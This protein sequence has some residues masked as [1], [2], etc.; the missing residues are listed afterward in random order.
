MR[1]IVRIQGEVQTPRTDM[2]LIGLL[3]KAHNWFA[4]LTSGR[5]NSVCAIAKE[6]GLTRAYVNKVIHLAFLAPGIVA[7]CMRGD[8]PPE[9][10][11]YRLI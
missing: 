6:E 2:K 1:L 9:L 3:A 8:H 10:N 5:Y 7:R 11:A 4:K